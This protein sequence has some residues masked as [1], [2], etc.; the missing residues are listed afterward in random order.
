MMK[1]RAK[2]AQVPNQEGEAAAPPVAQVEVVPFDQAAKKGI[3]PGPSWTFRLKKEGQTIKEEPLPAKGF[4]RAVLVD[5]RTI[6]AGTEGVKKE[7]KLKEDGPFSL[8][9][10]L[11]TRDTEGSPLFEL[12]GFLALQ[13]NI[14]AGISGSPDPREDPLFKASVLEPSFCLRIPY[15]VARNGMGSL[16][17]QS[18]SSTYKIG[19]ELAGEEAWAEKFE[20]GELPEIEIKTFV[21]L[22][23]EPAEYDELQRPC[24]QTPPYHGTAQYY[25]Q[26]TN[27]KVTKGEN[28]IIITRTG[29]ELRTIIF[30]CR[31]KTG[32]RNDKVFPDPWRENWDGELLQISA[33]R[34]LRKQMREGLVTVNKID[35]G[36]FVVSFNEGESRFFGGNEFNTWKPTL[37]ATRLEYIGSSEEEG[38]VDVMVNDVSIAETDPEVRG[39]MGSS[40]GYKPPVGLRVAGAR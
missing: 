26:Y 23:T 34:V 40:T 36:V 5:I 7:Q 18:M 1:K 22:W 24:A 27:Q 14:Y 20:A 13:S 29:S 37:T 19:G 28:K 9:Q 17:N 10:I 8:F 3:E 39:T 16:A 25:T 33:Q 12:G 6:K 2:H 15:E 4:I 32:K 31:D 30:V 11:R 21:E 35:T 38:T